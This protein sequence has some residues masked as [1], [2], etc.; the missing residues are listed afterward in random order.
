MKRAITTQAL[1][2]RIGDIVD[3][4]RLRGDRYI[5]ER[6]GKPVA[7]LV[8][9]SI[10]DQ[11]ERNRERFFQLVEQVHASNRDVP[12]SD[13]ESAVESAVREVRRAKVTRTVKK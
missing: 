6:R 9:V 7:A 1:K 10:N 2:A 4:V 13:I 8:P 11:Y 12:V 3:E 5:I